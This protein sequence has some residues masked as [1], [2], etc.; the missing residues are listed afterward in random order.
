MLGTPPAFVLSQD[1]TLYKMVFRVSDIESP[2]PKS[3]YLEFAL[4]FTQ[5]FS[6]AVLAI[7]ILTIDISEQ[8]SDVSIRLLSMVFVHVFVV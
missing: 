2:T 4:S 8:L 7:S 3:F 1:Q 5:E 6:L